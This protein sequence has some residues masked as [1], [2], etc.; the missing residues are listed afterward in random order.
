MSTV[1]DTEQELRLELVEVGRRLYERGFIAGTDGNLSVRLG[2]DR[3]LTT[4]SGVHKG[5]LRPEQIVTCD[6]EGRPVD[7]RRPSSEIRMHVLVYQA[8][9]D[10]SAAIHAHPVHSVALS[11]VG[12][13]LAECLLPE[14]AL[15]LGS[16]P[17][18]PYATPTTEDVPSSIRE[19]L[20]QRYNALILAR[21]GTLTL[22]RT[23]EEA[24]L[25]LETVE[26]T[27][28]ITAVARSIGAT[29][30]LP[31][32]E[33]ERIEAIARDLG[34]ARPDAGC[35]GCG[36]CGRPLG[37]K[38]SMTG[39]PEPYVPI[40]HHALMRRTPELPAEELERIQRAADEVCP[41][42]SLGD[43]QD[44]SGCVAAATTHQL[45]DELTAAVLRR[46]GHDRVR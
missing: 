35:S 39:S 33:V 19:L 40:S 41:E 43:S 23:L 10:V 12:V 6:L 14:P 27:A 21:H 46:L 26:H 17:T 34:I 24:V 1:I 22:G 5:M 3:M 37:D 18:A 25:R 30:A 11:L 31:A 36:T 9:P 15:A 8:R 13:S 28:K 7:D 42:A 44:Y 38:A 16:I 45:V 29:S 20:S 4:P 2:A 32:E